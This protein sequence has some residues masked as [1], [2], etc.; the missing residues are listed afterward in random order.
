MLQAARVLLR[1]QPL[2]RRP[3]RTGS[4]GVGGGREGR[5]RANQR[6]GCWLSPG[7]HELAE[8]ETS[9][10]NADESCG[11]GIGQRC[12]PDAA[13]PE[14]G[15]QA[16]VDGMHDGTSTTHADGFGVPPS[17]PGP[18]PSYKSVA[19]WGAHDDR[20]SGHAAGTLR[21]LGHARTCAGQPPL[22]ALRS[23]GGRRGGGR[24][25]YRESRGASPSSTMSTARSTAA[26]SPGALAS[27]LI[28]T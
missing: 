23:G 14:H 3:P 25:G 9:E 5:E 26:R 28:S 10:R 15:L 6:V 7:H 21:R 4:A 8:R 12:E 27:A 2:R 1:V 22:A 11:Q 17:R 24:G 18:R 13:V 20:L 19:L 16:F